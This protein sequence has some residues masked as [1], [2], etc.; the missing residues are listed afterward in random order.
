MP[1]K[2]LL[3]QLRDDL[4]AEHEVKMIKKNGDFSIKDLVVINTLRDPSK[5]PH[6]DELT[7]YQGIITGASGQYDLSC[8]TKTSEKKLQKVKPIF[9]EIIKKDIPNLAICFGHQ[10][11]AQIMGG[12]VK[13]DKHQAETGTYKIYLNKAGQ[14]SP[15]FDGC[16]KSFY[17]VLGHK[18]SVTKTP[19]N[20]KKLAS[21]TR[22]NL[23]SYQVSKN[24]YSVQFHPELN[25]DGLQWR[26][27]QYP[28]YLKGTTIEKVMAKFKPTPYSKKVISNF[29]KIARQ[30][31]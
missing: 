9:Q 26:I 28:Q 8:L 14:N 1:K 3:L 4:S 12:K 7:N 23:M 19:K 10:Y 27:E 25:K 29:K 30:S 5:V 24:I 16:P 18:D 11:I 22:C 6:P 31:H 21:S 15:L 17:A 2:F 13:A 20:L